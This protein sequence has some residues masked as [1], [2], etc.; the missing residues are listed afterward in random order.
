VKVIVWFGSLLIGLPLLAVTIF[1]V[2]VIWR[3]AF[4]M[5]RD[6]WRQVRSRKSRSRE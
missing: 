3:T 6:L 5:S 1:V 4:H 2:V